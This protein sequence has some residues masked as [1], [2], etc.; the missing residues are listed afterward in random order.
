MTTRHKALSA[1]KT[2]KRES[3]CQDE[4]M[5]NKVLTYLQRPA[6]TAHFLG[7]KENTIYN[8]NDT[9]YVIR[10]NELFY[11]NKDSNFERPLVFET[12]DIFK[13]NYEDNFMSNMYE[14]PNVGE[15]ES[16]RQDA[17]IELEVFASLGLVDKSNDYLIKDIFEYLTN[18]AS[19]SDHFGWRE[20][21]LYFNITDKTG[22]N[23][24]IQ[25][26]ILYRQVN[27]DFYKKLN[28]NEDLDRLLKTLES[29]R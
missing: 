1:L 9:E 4:T 23:Y 28:L 7:L 11:K 22:Y 25:D 20:G 2:L 3:F 21:Y 6:S 14:I 16:L 24:K 8:V 13:Y 17:I 27:D 15:L 12:L 19:L 26:G 18:K 10:H 29:K 5:L